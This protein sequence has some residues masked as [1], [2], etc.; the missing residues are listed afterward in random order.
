MAKREGNERRSQKPGPYGGGHAHPN[1]KKNPE[2][3]RK[4]NGDFARSVCE[5]AAEKRVEIFGPAL[6]HRV[7][8]AIHARAGNSLAGCEVQSKPSLLEAAGESHVF[9][10]GCGDGAMPA[11]FFI[12][13]A[14]NQNELAVGSGIGHG[15][16]VHP[17]EIEFTREA[18]IDKR[19]ERTLKHCL[20]E[21]LRGI[22]NE[23]GVEAQGIVECML[24][25]AGQQDGIRVSKEQPIAGG[26][27]SAKP[28]SVIF[29][30][31]TERQL[32]R[33]QDFQ[34]WDFCGELREN[35]GRPVGGLI[36]NDY[37]FADFG[38]RGERANGGC[39]VVFFVASRDDG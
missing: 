10:H 4:R 22:G 35:F 37:N 19:D 30:D 18:A 17:R 2:Q 9:Q 28:K 15:R 6:P 12:G 1:D 3:P 20:R 31:P 36:I 5:R 39:D 25:C 34:A 14:V 21:L 11:H 24:S 23:H 33:A 27:L 32:D 7:E 29:S 8:A 26:D 38:L 13:I 16:I